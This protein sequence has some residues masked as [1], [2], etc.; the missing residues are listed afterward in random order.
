MVKCFLFITDL[1]ETVLDFASNIKLASNAVLPPA[2]PAA[3]GDPG[4]ASAAFCQN[5]ATSI[6][7]SLH[8]SLNDVAI[9]SSCGNYAI[10]AYLENLLFFSKEWK[11]SKGEASGYYI[12]Q[13][14]SNMDALG[15]DGFA[16]RYK[17]TKNSVDYELEAK[18][19]HG[20][21]EQP[22]YLLPMVRIRIV[23]ELHAAAFCINSAVPSTAENSSFA[24]HLK[25]LAVRLKRIKILDSVQSKF[26]AELTR[27]NAIYPFLQKSCRSYSIPS[28]V[29]QFFLADVFANP[30]LPR[31]CFL[32][33]TTSSAAAGSFNES[34]FSFKPFNLQDVSLFCQ[35]KR[36]PSIPYNLD[37]PNKKYLQAYTQLFGNDTAFQDSPCA[38]QRSHFAEEFCIFAFYFGK[39]RG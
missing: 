7:K 35:N 4:Y 13:K 30:F 25:D 33:L 21:F 34:P 20:L 10:L 28:N 18:L 2:T 11:D 8:V 22:R 32:T 39:V 3:Q 38:I 16:K 31:Y 6:F 36:F 29:R 19:F 15:L 9:T 5:P 17:M 27:K 24:Y 12:S 26:E 37:F 1:S 23:F 14:P